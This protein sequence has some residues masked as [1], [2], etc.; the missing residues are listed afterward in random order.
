MCGW[1]NITRRHSGYLEYLPIRSMFVSKLK[2]RG[3]QRFRGGGEK[4]RRVKETFQ[5]GAQR[6]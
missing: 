6:P 2:R 5:K 3:C 4:E 1:V